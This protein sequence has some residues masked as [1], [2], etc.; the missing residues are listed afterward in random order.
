MVVKKLF[1]LLIFVFFIAVASAI[2]INIDMK[3]EFT[4]NEEIS[5]DYTISSEEDLEISYYARVDC[6]YAPVPE[7]GKKQAEIKANQTITEKYTYYLLNKD[8]ETQ[9]C[10]AVVAILEPEEII[11]EKEFLIIGEKGFSF[12]LVFNKKIF[13]LN[14]EIKIDYESN[15]NPDIEAILI[16]P[17][18]SREE[19]HLPVEIKALQVGTYEIEVKAEKEG[20]K[21]IT[22][23]EQIGVIENQVEVKKS[24]T[25]EIDGKCSGEENYQ[26]CPQ[27]CEIEAR[28]LKPGEYNL[29]KIKSGIIFY[30]ILILVIVISIILVAIGVIH[31]KRK[32]DI[33]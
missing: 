9:T 26:N 23:K 5:F 31:Y 25:C 6:T 29:K 24:S 30:I 1:L 33:S 3:N 16:Y 15:I 14:D 17:D 8:I 20:Y 4:L 11:K 12:E 19:I 32:S 2:E 7:F 22:K 18:K 27:D 10:K 21:T 13:V 28:T